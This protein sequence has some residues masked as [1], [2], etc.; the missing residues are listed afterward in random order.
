LRV[1]FSACW[2]ATTSIVP[3]VRAMWKIWA[4]LGPEDAANAGPLNGNAAS[5]TTRI[6]VRS[7]ILLFLSAVLGAGGRPIRI[8]RNN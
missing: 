1:F 3:A 4:S 5:A 2:P 6:K 8:A 7:M